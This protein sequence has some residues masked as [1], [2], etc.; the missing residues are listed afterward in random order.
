MRYNPKDT[1]ILHCYRELICVQQLEKNRF[2][3]GDQKSI[4]R[5]DPNRHNRQQSKL[6]K[7]A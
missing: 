4:G 3:D 1:C 6:N 7:I 5:F 2:H